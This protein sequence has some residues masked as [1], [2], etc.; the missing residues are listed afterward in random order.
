ML[1]LLYFV[2]IPAIHPERKMRKLLVGFVLL[3]MTA[4]AG[5]SLWLLFHTH[6]QTIVAEVPEDY[7]RTADT[8]RFSTYPINLLRAHADDSVVV[9]F[10]TNAESENISVLVYDSTQYERLMGGDHHAAVME[11]ATWLGKLLQKPLVNFSGIP[12]GSY[13]ARLSSCNYGGF[14]HVRLKTAK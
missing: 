3:L 5:F 12:D 4:V 10:P 14:I 7:L 9:V 1:V 11:N 8:L 13:F 6:R 2:M